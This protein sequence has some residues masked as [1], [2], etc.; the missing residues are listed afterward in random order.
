MNPSFPP[1]GIPP[2]N[3]P[4]Q[5]FGSGTPPVDPQ[6]PLGGSPQQGGFG[7]GSQYPFGQPAQN[8]FEP[9]Q[10]RRQR[11]LIPLVVGLVAVVAI[12]AG[13]GAVLLWPKKQHGYGGPVGVAPKYIVD[14]IVAVGKNPNDV[15][16]DPQSHAIYVPNLDDDSISVID[17][18][19]YAVTTTITGINSPYRLALNSAKHR[20][21][22]TTH[23][24][25]GSRG[26]VAVVDTVANKVVATIGVGVNPK[27]IAFDPDRGLIY[28][29][30]ENLDPN[31]PDQQYVYAANPGS[32]SV[33]DAAT[34]SVTQTIGVGRGPQYA[35]LD[36]NARRLYISDESES[37]I[38]VVDTTAGT[39]VAN[40]GVGEAALG[41]TVDPDTHTLYV[42]NLDGSSVSVVD[43][44]TNTVRRT[45]PVSQNPRVVAVDK[46]R[47][48]IYVA[49]TATPDDPNLT[50]SADAI[51]AT[52]FGLVPVPGVGT[53]PS[54]VA[55][56]VGNGA[57][58]IADS[59]EG[60]VYVVKPC[61]TCAAL[62]PTTTEPTK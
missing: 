36:T 34:N 47:K 20:L 38:A 13:V 18:T 31:P 21:Y 30:N 45:L 5:P 58:F 28:V 42:A 23:T 29:V 33:I 19:T 43:T 10:K 7:A 24:Q 54:W 12:A 53:E 56:D 1:G 9:A 3:G 16:V 52:T 46:V 27:G 11:W 55:V 2:E 57:V 50:V 44:Q 49:H 25:N 48:T 14:P 22:A 41:V 60:K 8:S 37:S 62:P 4:T 51:D 35:A 26:T 6:Q 17:G 15:A 32:V 61:Y 59:R 39:V 40:I